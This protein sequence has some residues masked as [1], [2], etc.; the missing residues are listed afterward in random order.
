MRLAA[1]QV[2]AAIE[3]VRVDFAGRSY[4]RVVEPKAPF[5]LA[6]RTHGRRWIRVRKLDD[7]VVRVEGGHALGL[8]LGDD[9]MVLNHVARAVTILQEVAPQRSASAA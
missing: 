4:L 2:D 7:G 9:G 3:R 8:P 1:D 5:T 6:Y